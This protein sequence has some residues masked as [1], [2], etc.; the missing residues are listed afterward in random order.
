MYADANLLEDLPQEIGRLRELQ[1]LSLKNNKLTTLPATMGGLRNLKFLDVQNNSLD[2][3]PSELGRLTTLTAAAASRLANTRRLKDGLYLERNPLPDPFPRLIASGQPAATANVLAWLRGELD[4]SSL[5]ANNASANEKLPIPLEPAIE[6]GPSFQVTRGKYDLIA[7]PEV[8]EFDYSAQETL[9]RRLRKQVALL[10]QENLKV[11]NQHPLLV[12]TIDEYALLISS[13]LAEIDVLDVWS[14]G[15]SV[16]AQAYAFERQDGH[17]TISEPLEPVHL[18]LLIEVSRLH[19][20]FILGFPKGLELTERSDA[21]RMAP[22][23]ARIIEPSAFEIL[24]SFSKQRRL[25][26]DRARGLAD[27]LEAGLLTASWN[28]ARVGHVSYVMLRN[29]LIA[30]GKTV[31]LANDQ[32]STAVGGILLSAAIQTSGLTPEA[33]VQLLDFIRANTAAILS[34]VAPFPELRAWVEWMINHFDEQE[35]KTKG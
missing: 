25:F 35:K 3:L 18:A 27:A 2:R 20:G 21:A 32:S 30:A 4:L 16:L 23:T 5:S 33:A 1:R 19:G 15:T 12:R 7:D 34:F 28:T 26:S 10:Q 31:L 24:S 9:L 29:F 14:V 8:G 6:R 11:G 13:P 17:R 22:D